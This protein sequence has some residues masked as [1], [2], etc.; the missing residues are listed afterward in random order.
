VIARIIDKNLEIAE[1]AYGKENIH[2]LY[3]LSSTITN[4]IALGVINTPSQAN[5]L[6]ARMRAIVSKFHGGDPRAL[7]NQLI[8]QQQILYA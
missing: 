7:A 2:L 1:K 4:R 5:P 6:I 3:Y 8:F